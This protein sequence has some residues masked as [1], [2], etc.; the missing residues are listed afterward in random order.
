[1]YDLAKQKGY[2]LIHLMSR[3][4]NIFFV[5][6]QYYDRFG[7]EDN[8]PVAMWHPPPRILGDEK[9]YSKD[10]QTLKIDAFEIEKKWIER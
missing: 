1:M 7:I 9:K 6:K 4:P 3:G 8:S 5:D 10:K 2:E